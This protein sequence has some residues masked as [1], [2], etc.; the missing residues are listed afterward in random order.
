[1]PGLSNG[2]GLGGLDQMAF[3]RVPMG[4][5]DAGIGA[6]PTL[7]QPGGMPPTPG[8]G[9]D[10]G[11]LQLIL[12]WLASMNPGQGQAPVGLSPGLRTFASTPPAEGR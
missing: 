3:G 11:L 1:M 4:A 8:M 2:L 10:Q 12:R 7:S 6:G 5:G 9:G